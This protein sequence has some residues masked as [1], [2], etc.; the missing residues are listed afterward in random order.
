MFTWE[1][2]NEDPSNLT[3]IIFYGGGDDGRYS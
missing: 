1:V 2:S 3:F